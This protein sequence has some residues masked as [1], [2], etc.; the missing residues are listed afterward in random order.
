MI[1]IVVFLVIFLL[2]LIVAGA[3]FVF[4]KRYKEAQALVRSLTDSEIDEFFQGKP[5]LLSN[6]TNGYGHSQPLECID[7]LPYKREYELSLDDI[8][9]GIKKF[10][11]KIQIFNIFLTIFLSLSCR[12][13]WYEFSWIRGVFLCGKRY[14]SLKIQT[15]CCKDFKANR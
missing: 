1:Y 12:S 2:L 10:L 11:L 4:M 5:E 3:L 15:R 6:A 7:F 8:E 13:I 14:N 9:F